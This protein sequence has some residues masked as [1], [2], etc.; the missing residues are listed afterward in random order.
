MVHIT[1]YAD[2][3]LAK[4][5]E[6]WQTQYSKSNIIFQ[7]PPPLKTD[8]Q[9]SI[10]TFSIPNCSFRSVL[11]KDIITYLKTILHVII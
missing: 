3:P 2:S 6:C 5:H 1:I 7:P 11:R 10:L 8:N 4:R 9:K